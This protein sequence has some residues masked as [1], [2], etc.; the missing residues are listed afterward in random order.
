MQVTVCKVKLAYHRTTN[1]I[2]NH[3]CIKHTEKT[4]ETDDTR[5]LITSF[6]SS[7]SMCRFDSTRVE[8]ISE[9]ITEIVTGDM[10][11][12]SFVEGGGFLQ[13]DAVC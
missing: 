2:I 8:K 3:L 11:V 5:F 12:L 7:F 9:L 6:A 13:P 4:A 10:L 1:S